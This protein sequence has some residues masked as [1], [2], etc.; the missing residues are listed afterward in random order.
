ML[1][2]RR[3]KIVATIGPAT[4]DPDNLKK[5]IEAGM[6]VARLNFSHGHHA[7]H[8]D[9]IQNL[10]RISKELKAPVTILQDLQGPK[11]RVGLFEKGSIVLKPREVVTVTIEDVLGR[12]GLI[13][14]DFKE[15]CKACKEGTQILLDDGLI[16][17][18]VL[19]VQDTELKAEVIYGGI[20][21]NRKGMNLPGVPLPVDAM[22]TKDKEDLEFG[23]KNSVDYIAL[24]F[25]RYGKDIRILR[26][27]I[28]KAGSQA[29]IVA[30]IEMLEALDNLEE[31]VRLSDVVMVARGDLAVEIGQSRLPSSQKR[32]IN[33]C[34]QLGKPVITATQ[35]LD[36]MVENPRP[37]RAE[38]TDVANAVLDGTDALMLSAESASGK[39]PF[40]AIRT[41]HEIIVEVEKNEDS[42]YKISLDNELLSTPGAIAASSALSA[43]KL[44]A[45]AIV[46]LTTSGRTAQIIAGFRPKAQI[47][48]MTT[49]TDVLNRLEITWGLQTLQIRPYETLKDV[50]NQM[51]K[52]LIENGLAKT[53]DRIILTLGQPIADHGKTNALHVHVLGGEEYKKSLSG[54]LPLRFKSLSD[55]DVS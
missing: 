54:D 15:L 5:A 3:A 31:I 25:V 52:H 43:L 46:C 12:E 38:I 32:I 21:K 14:S 7:E 23:L 49:E 22:T 4:R 26:E 20:L 50:L 1:A 36:S 37:T 19:S 35:M 30:K 51:E 48:A 10:R 33:L 47:V 55:I 29:K 28:E 39:H 42:Y 13:P 9:V 17:L 2:T 27:L 53:G 16:E 6:N 41:M 8:L 24:S 45:S 34:N 44:N 18:K 40:R 11:V